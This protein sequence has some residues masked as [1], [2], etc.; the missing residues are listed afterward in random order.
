MNKLKSFT[1]VEA[2]VVLILSA[3]VISISYTAISI[4]SERIHKFKEF[5]QESEAITSA[6]KVLIND[7]TTA[8]YIVRSP[9]GFKCI[10]NEHIVKYDFSSNNII[11]T[12]SVSDVFN[13]EVEGFNTFYKGLENFVPGS[14][15]DQVSINIIID[16]S[17][18]ELVFV[19]Q[20]GS[21][22]LMNEKLILNG[23]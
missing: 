3:L 9:E 23:N 11:R 17:P 18:F 13:L 21:D 22:I 2:I 1:I 19:K 5:I 16:N 7:I 14:I 15:L 8:K 10:Y 12:G 6:E 20:Y 4:I